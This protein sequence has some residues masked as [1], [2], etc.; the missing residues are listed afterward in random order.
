LYI[1]N[2]KSVYKLIKRY[3]SQFSHFKKIYLVFFG[4]R[5]LKS[6]VEVT[7]VCPFPLSLFSIFI[8]IMNSIVSAAKAASTITAGRRAAGAPTLLN[9]SSLST[10]TNSPSKENEEI[11]LGP[12]TGSGAIAGSGRRS[13]PSAAS[14][15][16]ETTTTGPAF[17]QTTSGS[18]T[19]TKNVTIN[20]RAAIAGTSALFAGNDDGTVIIRDDTEIID[21]EAGQTTSIAPRNQARRVQTL[22]ELQ[23][24]S[25]GSGALEGRT[26]VGTKNGV[27]T[28]GNVATTIGLDLSLLTSVMSPPEALK[29]PDEVWIY[30]KLL[31][32]LSQDLAREEDKNDQEDSK[33]TTKA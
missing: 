23:E 9:T 21:T 31:Q 19:S 29:E 15:G 14:W 4:A 8:Y 24:Q 18:S 30:N 6:L 20:Q 13:Q 16:S 28:S 17:G 25:A 1:Y 12:S 26:S 7:F 27:N 3:N 2:N 10:S 32:Q 33:L 5:K 11:A 22:S